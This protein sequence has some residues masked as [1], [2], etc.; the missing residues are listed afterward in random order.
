MALDRRP[1]AKAPDR[2]LALELGRATEAAAIAAAHWMGMGNKKAADLAAV[3]AMSTVMQTVDMDGVVIIGEGDKHET[4]RL[5][6]GEKI[7]NGLLPK[8]DIA[9]DPIDG[10]TL[11]TLGRNNA[12]SVAALSERNTMINPR[13]SVYM[14]KMVV[15]KAAADVI[16]LQAPIEDNLQKV[17]KAKDLEI[18]DLVAIVLD[19]DRHTE[20]IGEIREAGARVKLIPDGDISG[21]ILAGHENLTGDILIGIGG[22]AE[23]IIAACALH[24]LGGQILARFW[25]RNEAER[26][27]AKEQGHDCQQILTKDDLVSGEDVFFSATG[28]THGEMLNG[29]VFRGSGA[30]T[31]S[32][33]MRSRS[34]TIREIKSY[35]DREKLK[36]IEAVAY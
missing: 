25:P 2:N 35:H 22:T 36:K 19:R 28:I 14:E 6:H 12:I 4:D 15:G 10:T 11:L 1:R 34:G 21:A 17:A 7:G 27:A 3:E 20:L 26:K 32:L 18:T 33:I 13:P 8:T 31:N 30:T 5:Y 23:G 16:D 24:C 29:V 9:V